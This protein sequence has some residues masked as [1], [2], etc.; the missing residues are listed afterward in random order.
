ML[1]VPATAAAAWQ[2]GYGNAS[3]ALSLSLSAAFLA[4]AFFLP[5][6]PPLSPSLA[7]LPLC[8]VCWPKQLKTWQRA[9]NLIEQV[10]QQVDNIATRGRGSAS[11]GGGGAEGLQLPCGGKW[12]FGW[13]LRRPA[14][15]QR[16]VQHT[17]TS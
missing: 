12:H 14:G 1:Q 10:R 3:A 7:H 16:G 11:G 13:L 9:S 5:L 6:S 15:I 4:L 2:T 8:F 17:R